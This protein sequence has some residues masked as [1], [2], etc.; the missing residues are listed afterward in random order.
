MSFTPISADTA[1]AL[2]SFVDTGTGNL[3]TGWTPVWTPVAIK[4]SNY[5]SVFQ[6]TD[7][8]L[9]LVVQGTKNVLDALED[10]EVATQEDFKWITGAKIALGTEQA[11]KKTLSLAD[12]AGTTL[13]QYLTALESGSQ[14]LVT[15]HSLGGNLASAL[16]PWIAGTVPAF[17]GPHHPLA[18]LPASIQGITF[19]APTAGNAAFAAFLNAQSNYQANFNLNDVIPHVWAVTEPLN[20]NDI[21]KMFVGGPNPCPTKIWDKIQAKLTKIQGKGLNYTQTK[22]QFFTFPIKQEPTTESATV[23]WLSELAYQHNN[24]Y[25]SQFLGDTRERAS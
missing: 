3:P 16:A 9:A 22:G 17:G 20:A 21:Q 1:Y 2:C 11:K 25:A 7:G 4:D 13:E 14:L 24:A 5:A 8:T 18:A 6:Y 10:F 23:Q 15:G 12:T 19:A